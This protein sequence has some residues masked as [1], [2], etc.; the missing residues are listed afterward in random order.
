[1]KKLKKVDLSNNKINKV[2]KVFDQN[3]VEFDLFGNPMRATSDA[4][5][6]EKSMMDMLKHRLR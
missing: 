4:I 1:M 6:E 3:K 2:E 5:I